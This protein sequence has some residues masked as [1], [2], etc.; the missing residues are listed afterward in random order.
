MFN[1]KKFIFKAKPLLFKLSKKSK[2][3]VRKL[4]KKI[5]EGKISRQKIKNVINAL[6]ESKATRNWLRLAIVLILGGLFAKKVAEVYDEEK[7]FD[8]NIKE[9]KGY[10]KKLKKRMKTHGC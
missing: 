10:V 8:E 2:G 9:L 4:V 6:D 1:A 3:I 5:K 7:T